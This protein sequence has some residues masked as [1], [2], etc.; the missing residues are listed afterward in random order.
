MLYNKSA[1]LSARPCKAVYKIEHQKI[2]RAITR[3]P[4]SQKDEDNEDN[5]DDKDNE[6]DEDEVGTE[7][8]DGHGDAVEV[9][10]EWGGDGDARE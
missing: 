9:E 4:A 7:G 6:D 5:E 10:V 3:Q 1:M 8:E 2:L